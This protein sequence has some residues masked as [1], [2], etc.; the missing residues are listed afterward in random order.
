MKPQKSDLTF[1]VIAMSRG[2]LCHY[3]HTELRG[4]IVSRAGT[5]AT[6]AD[7]TGATTAAA[8][9]YGTVELTQTAHARCEAVTHSLLPGEGRDSKPN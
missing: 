5:E 2:Q 6:T 9:T 3:S 1:T 4:R 8:N 7:P